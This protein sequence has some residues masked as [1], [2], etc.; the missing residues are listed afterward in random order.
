MTTFVSFFFS[1]AKTNHS[2]AV[3]W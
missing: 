2:T 3:G 1:A